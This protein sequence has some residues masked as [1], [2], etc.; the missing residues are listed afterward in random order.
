MTV[1]GQGSCIS[2]AHRWH[3]ETRR[4][5]CAFCRVTDIHLPVPAE[6]GNQRGEA[7]WVPARHSLVVFVVFFL[8]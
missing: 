2:L 3:R 4:L 5:P 6:A 8:R 1:K 7:L